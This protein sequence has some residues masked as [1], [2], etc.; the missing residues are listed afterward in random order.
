MLIGIDGLMNGLR[1]ALPGVVIEV[2][3]RHHYDDR[4]FILSYK[5][6]DYRFA[7]AMALESENPEEYE[8]W[9][10]NHFRRAIVFFERS[11]APEPVPSKAEVKVRPS[12]EEYDKVE[13]FGRF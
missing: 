2:Q 10:S 7:L 13:G 11:S 1:S 6:R 5:G 9:V 8:K 4:C 12:K 3:R